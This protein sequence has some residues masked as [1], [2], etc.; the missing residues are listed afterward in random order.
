VPPHLEEQP[1]DLGL[2]A[3]EL[4]VDDAAVDVH[5][6]LDGARDSRQGAARRGAA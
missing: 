2:V 1:V 3:Q 6:A 5:V 4:V